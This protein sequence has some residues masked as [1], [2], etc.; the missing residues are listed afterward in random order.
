MHYSFQYGFPCLYSPHA[1]ARV[2]GMAWDERGRGKGIKILQNPNISI[3]CKIMRSNYIKDPKTSHQKIRPPL[4][5]VNGSLPRPGPGPSLRGVLRVR[6]EEADGLV[7]H[8][9]GQEGQQALEHPQV[10]ERRHGRKN[11]YLRFRS[12]RN[13]KKYRAK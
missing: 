2:L 3:Y 12:E 6:A 1:L 13:V 9:L 4:C 10:L 11:S 5:T 8:H 7:G